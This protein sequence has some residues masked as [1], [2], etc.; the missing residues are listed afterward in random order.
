ML[1]LWGWLLGFWTKGN[2]HGSHLSSQNTN[3]KIYNSTIGNQFIRRVKWSN[4]RTAHYHRVPSWPAAAAPHPTINPPQ[5]RPSP[6]QQNAPQ[7]S[8]SAPHLSLATP[9][10]FNCPKKFQIS[11]SKFIFP[12]N[13]LS[14]FIIYVQ[15]FLFWRAIE[16]VCAILWFII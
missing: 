7:L 2:F 11:C 1:L 13:I 4:F 12:A 5:L 10:K 9:T 6:A 14:K 8:L 15:P 16:I 3:T